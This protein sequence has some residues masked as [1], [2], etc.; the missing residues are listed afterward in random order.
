[1]R[2][3]GQN[4]NGG[5]S[6]GGGRGGFNSHRGGR[7]MTNNPGELPLPTNPFF[8]Q[9]QQQSL[10]NNMGMNNNPNMGQNFNN[11]NNN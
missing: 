10:F 9:H 8:M 3:S 11:Q 1:M 5:G 4:F 7:N 6:S 2:N